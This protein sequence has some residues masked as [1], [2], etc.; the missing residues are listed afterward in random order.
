ML[1][2]LWKWVKPVLA[3]INT[4][5][6][7]WRPPMRI[8]KV[9][10]CHNWNP[11]IPPWDSASWSKCYGRNGRRA[12]IILSTERWQQLQPHQETKNCDLWNFFPIWTRWI[13]SQF[14]I[15]PS[16][17]SMLKLKTFYRWF[18]R[19]WKPRMETLNKVFAVRGLLAFLAFIEFVNCARSLLP[20]HDKT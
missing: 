13:V 16:A 11:R 5:R 18:L 17:I 1:S 12:Q 2:V 15:L 10:D 14:A 20:R 8:L 19:W 4:L 9:W 7:G 6:K 3:L